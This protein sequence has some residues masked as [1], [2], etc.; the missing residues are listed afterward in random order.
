[1]MPPHT[2]WT[3]TATKRKHSS[4]LR[5]C[6]QKPSAPNPASLINLPVYLDILFCN[7]EIHSSIL[8]TLPLFWWEKTFNSM[9][10]TTL[11]KEKSTQK[12]L[13]GL[14]SFPLI[15][16]PE[17]ADHRTATQYFCVRK[18]CM[19]LYERLRASLLLC[20]SFMCLHTHRSF[21]FGYC[22]ARN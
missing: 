10:R 19:Y 17:F 6:S 3:W 4:P 5:S 15:A 21:G 1:M 13:V 12:Q 16:I 8:E 18:L 14:L 22:C 20:H 7:L 9:M 11:V 2:D